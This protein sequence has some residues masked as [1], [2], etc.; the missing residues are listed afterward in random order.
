MNENLNF[1]ILVDGENAQSKKYTDILN[2]V[3][4]K[5]SIAIK[6]VYA[7]WTL[8][9]NRGWKDIL[10]DT[11]SSPKQ[12]FHI[13]K[14][15]V[16]HALIMD[17][18]EIICT[19]DKINA[20]CIVSSD[21]GFAGLAQRTREKGLHVMAIGK[22]DTPSHFRNACHNFVYVE[23]LSLDDNQDKN[24]AVGNQSDD[25]ENLLLR[26]YWQLVGDSDTVYMGDLGTKLKQLD[27][28]F[29]PRNYGYRSLKKLIQNAST[30]LVTHSESEDR[31]Y[32]SL[33]TEKGH[34][35][36]TPKRANNFAF[37]V[38]QGHEYYFRKEDLLLSNQ[39]DKIKEGQEVTF[40]HSAKCNG[41]SPWASN[42]RCV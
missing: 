37:I 10:L 38:H 19:N 3:A 25:L 2:E 18:I 1:A 24:S 42:V 31:C 16:D 14:D 22:S 17:A 40:Q 6:W 12:Q 15:S 36:A 34:I 23:N 30:P 13:A 35:K 4:R 21:G 8:P 9:N 32:V 5:G 29:D 33:I 11:G 41:K 28:A 39:W 26:A 20:L 27:S 7:D